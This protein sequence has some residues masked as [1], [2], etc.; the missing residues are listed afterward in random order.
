MLLDDL[1]DLLL[2]EIFELVLLEVKAKLGTS[3]KGRID[4]VR[5]NSEGTTSSRFPDILL[6]IVVLSD[7]LDTLSD[8]VCR[9]ET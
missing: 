2:F 7:D 9:V 5:S 8:K 4:G 1:L 3:S 6:I